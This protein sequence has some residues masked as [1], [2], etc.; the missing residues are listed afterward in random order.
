MDIRNR[1]ALKQDAAR[2]LN[3]GRDPKKLI[4]Y[5]AGITVLVALA[6]TLINFLLEQQIA[7][8]GGLSNLGTRSMLSTVQTLLPIVQMV[9]L[10]CLEFGYLHGMLRI[11]RGQYA[12]HTDLKVG[13]H[14]YGP[15]LRITLLQGLLFAAIGVITF[16]VAIQI[17]LLTPWGAP[18]MEILLP[19]VEAGTTVLDEA[20]ALQV[21]EYMMPMLIIFLILYLVVVIPLA[22]RF[23]MANFALLDE[24]RAGAI[25]AL[26]ASRKM[27]RHNSISLLKLDLSFW[28]YYALQ[29][30]AT[31]LCYGD[32]ILVY[33]GVQLPFDPVVSSFLFYGIYLAV[34][35][36]IHYFLRNAV[37]A[38]YIM[39]YESLHEKPKDNGVVLGNIFDM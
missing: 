16:Y 36:G 17:F 3:R 12:D 37:E 28:W 21:G 22:Y 9:V 26:R 31:V 38:T 24:P 6:L 25:A 27:M 11:A 20:T 23:R 13:F 15:I 33:M 4:T 14:L 7:G 18:V 29:A 35:F 19:F 5:Y 30:L 32:L 1:S 10:M 2:A 8:K 39:A 34:L